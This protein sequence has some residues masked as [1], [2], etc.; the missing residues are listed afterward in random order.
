MIP[1]QSSWLASM[2]VNGDEV[3]LTTANGKRL[4]YTGVPEHITR[5]LSTAYSPGTIW[6][7][8]LRGQYGEK[9]L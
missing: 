1:L 8:L 4:R 7:Q 9:A 6:R 3:I 2:V 5:A